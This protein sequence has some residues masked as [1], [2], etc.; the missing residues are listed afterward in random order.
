MKEKILRFLNIKTSESGVVFDLMF[1]Q[2]FLGIATSFLTIVSYTLFLHN[3]AIDRLP[4]AYLFIAG[5]LVVINI[6][7][8]KLEHTLSP[9]IMLRIIAAMAIVTILMF[10][11]GMLVSN[12]TWI[13]FV[14]IVWGT[15]LY[16]LT[17]YAFW[18]L[19]SLLFNV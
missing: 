6:F 9:V 18:G 5:T 12:G 14:L 11:L 13:I 8:E 19:V 7:Y 1:V 16:M 10:W 4:E 2:L 3:Y 15:I 17:G